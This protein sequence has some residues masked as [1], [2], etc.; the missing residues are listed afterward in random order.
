MKAVGG[1][2]AIRADRAAALGGVDHSTPFISTA[3]RVKRGRGQRRNRRN[4]EPLGD[5]RVHVHRGWGFFQLHGIV[6]S[7]LGR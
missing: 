2:I 7:P 6:K 4:R 5:R 1:V 3:Y